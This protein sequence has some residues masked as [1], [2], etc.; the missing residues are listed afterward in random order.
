MVDW[1]VVIWKIVRTVLYG[2]NMN[3]VQSTGHSGGGGLGKKDSQIE[4]S[5][6]YK[7]FNY[8][9][10][11]PNFWCDDD[12]MIE[13]YFFSINLSETYVYTSKY[14]QSF[15]LTIITSNYKCSTVA[16]TKIKLKLSIF[17]V[18]FRWSNFTKKI[19]TFDF[20]FYFF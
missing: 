16:T 18:S 11:I 8:K 9:W 17:Y 10:K 7:S 4:V 13:S 20:S 19:Q 15:S 3:S 1:A 12:A 5:W 14:L 6:L 2:N